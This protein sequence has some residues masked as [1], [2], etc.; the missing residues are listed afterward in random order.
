M[1]IQSNFESSAN[2]SASYISHLVYP[3]GLSL[4]YQV[5]GYPHT[6]KAFEAC[7]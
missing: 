6:S 3:D 2:G 1:N 5:S 4:T 7:L